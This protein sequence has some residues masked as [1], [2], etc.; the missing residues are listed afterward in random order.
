MDDLKHRKHGIEALRIVAIYSLFGLVW[1]YG[2]DTVLGWLVHD[3]AVM[4]KIAV[5]KGSLFIFCTA[6]LLY[7]LINRFIRQL[8]SAET[9]QIESLKNYEAIFNATNEAIFVQ[10][11]KSGHILDINDRMLEIYGYTRE[12]AL[13]VGIGDLSEGVSPYSQAEAAEKVRRTLLE[14]PQVFVWHSRKKNGGLFWSEVSLRRI[15]IHDSDRIIAVVRDISDRKQLDDALLMREKRHRTI[16]DSA[17]DGFWI[18]SREGRLLE[19]NDAYCRMS[20]YSKQELLTMNIADFDVNETTNDAVAHNDRIMGQGE[21]RFVAQHRRK[22]GTVYDVEVSAKFIPIEGGILMAFL[23]DITDRNRMEESL[24]ESKATFKAFYDLGLV[25]LTITSPEKGWVNIN[26]CLCNMLGYTE[27]ELRTMTWDQL[28]HPDDLTADVEQFEQLLGGNIDGYELEKRFLTRSGGIVFTKL[29]VRCVRKSDRSVDFIAAMVEDITGHKQAETAL[30]ESASKIA[31]IVNNVPGHVAF[32]T[33]DTL[34]YEFVN[35]AFEK[36]F[37]IPREKIIGS[38]IK[39]IIGENNYRF[40][41]TYIKEVRAGKSASYENVFDL[42]SGKRWIQVNYNPITDSNGHVVSIAVHSFDITDHKEHENERLKIEKLESLG[43]LAG[44]IAHDFNNILTVIMGNISFARMFIDHTHKSYNALDGAEKATVRATELA[45]QLLTF[46]RG[47]TPVKKVVSLRNLVNE[48]VSMALHGSNVKAV[49]DIPDSIHAIEADEGQISQVFHNIIINATQS[50]PGGGTLT[51]T[52]RNEMLDNDMSMS[53]SP[54]SYIR[55][56]FTDEG[57][58]IPDT[59][60][61]KIFDPYF[62]TKVSGHGLGLASCRSIIVKHGGNISVSSTVNTGSTF[63]L[64]LPSIGETI[65]DCRIVLDTQTVRDT[66]GGSV[67]VMDDEEMI[68]ELAAGLLEEIGYQVTMCHDGTEAIRHYKAAR[69]S[70]KPFSAVIMDLTIPGGMGGIEAAKEIL[71]IDPAARLIVSSGYSD[72]PVMSDYISYGFA[73]AIAKPYRV[74]E[75]AHIL[76][77]SLTD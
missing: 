13:A 23:R 22:N 26:E 48:T 41:L 43:V 54:G 71:G 37:G 10:D 44:G 11:A 4:V 1:I 76:R 18:V 27:A 5:I 6:T 72:S 16:L 67:L 17:M 45:R 73:G 32:V 65:P 58:G 9:G 7:F 36:S 55:L 38:F 70:G 40:A 14:G 57:C 74:S 21:D 59:D 20:G 39:D 34:K 51:V 50:M 35:D 52:A 47:G 3:P 49:I 8:T 75:L 12:E 56:L 64:H 19:I 28:T 31:S 77:S 68:L 66:N 30:K 2:S 62:T 53:L 42:V 33:A 24:R 46:A 61:N 15:S 69:D 29:V 63:T 60:L 25:G